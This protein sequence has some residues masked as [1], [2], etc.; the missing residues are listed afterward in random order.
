MKKIISVL[1]LLGF[2]VSFSVLPI[3]G[4]TNNIALAACADYD[5]ETDCEEK[6]CTWD[7][8]GEEDECIG[9]EEV[10][11]MGAL[12]RIT[13]W[14]FAILI[15]IAAMFLIIAG[16]QYI[17]AQGDPEKIKAAHQKV[18][19]SLIGVIVALLAKGL[20]TLMERIIGV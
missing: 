18:L 15:A 12:D 3:I 4:V 11:V 6:G 9:I 20:V 2:F 17:S 13:N 10:D 14:L 7:T 5:N 19:Y 16:I 8:S 1:L